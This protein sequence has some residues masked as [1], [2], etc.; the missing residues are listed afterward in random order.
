MFKQQIL[1]TKNKRKNFD[2]FK[3]YYIDIEILVSKERGDYM[4]I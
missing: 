1:A 4:I 2:I 3:P